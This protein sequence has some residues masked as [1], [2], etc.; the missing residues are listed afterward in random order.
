M[1][2]GSH[3]HAHTHTHTHTNKHTRVHT[4]GKAPRARTTSTPDRASHS[5]ASTHIVIPCT[6]T[7][8]VVRIPRGCVGSVWGQC[9]GSVW[10]RCGVSVH[11]CGVGL[12]S[13]W[14]SVLGSHELNITFDAPADIALQ[15]I[16]NA[17][18]GLN[19]PGRGQ[20]TG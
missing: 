17:G 2:P 5:T 19:V 4:R 13:E 18:V 1:T 8:E 15:R 16:D 10:D 20:K 3:T 6:A 9:A 12:G 7:A 14:G 11:Q